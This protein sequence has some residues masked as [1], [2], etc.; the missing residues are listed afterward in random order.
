VEID[1][2]PLPLDTVD[3]SRNI[4][5]VGETGHLIELSR[6]FDSVISNVDWTIDSES[7]IDSM[8]HACRPTAM[9][10]VDRAGQ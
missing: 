6:L 10:S 4:D 3:T 2:P 5:T 9:D 1:R 7:S 8:S